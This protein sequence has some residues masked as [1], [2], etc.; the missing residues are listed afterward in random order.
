MW[1]ISS[2]TLWIPLYI[3][4]TIMLFYKY[5]VRRS[6]ICLLSIALMIT[7]VDQTCSTLIRPLIGRM[8][9]SN[10][11]NPLAS[12]IH[13]VNSYRGGRFGFPSCHA[14]NCF[15]LA[16]FLS[17]VFRKGIII[18]FLFSWATIVSWSRIYLGVHY[19]GDILVGASIGSGLAYMVYYLK[20]NIAKPTNFIKVYLIKF[21]IIPR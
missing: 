15:A 1:A 9:P 5:S 4:L 16:T 18:S 21:G 11:D 17:L 13:I 20:C 10:P 3:L 14:A 12:I 6:I 19:P 8:R 2:K 7:L